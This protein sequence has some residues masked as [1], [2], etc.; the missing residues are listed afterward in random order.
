M[1]LAAVV[2]RVVMAA[3]GMQLDALP[4]G[5]ETMAG[6]ENGGLDLALYADGNL[7][8]DFYA[9]DLFRERYVCLVRQGHPVLTH[10][11]RDER[12]L[13]QAL[14]EFPRAIMLYP[15]GREVLPDD[16]LKE[17]LGAPCAR[18][19]PFRT[20]Y[21][22]SGP[23]AVAQSDMVMCL[24]ARAAQLM[25]RLGGLVVLDVPQEAGFTYRLI[26][27]ARSHADP[28]MRWVRTKFCEAV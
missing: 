23:L 24:P 1:V 26:W 3:P 19:I 10:R 28:M 21:F 8:G 18:H 7:P 27:H 22:L 9:R 5:G 25:A 20:S 12:V 14:A 4:W 13:V 17:Q 6:L 16:A 2:P 11:A 15:D